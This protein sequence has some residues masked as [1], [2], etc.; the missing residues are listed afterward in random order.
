MH[1]NLQVIVYS[2]D[3]PW[4]LAEYLRTFRKFISSDI[5]PK[6]IW[7]ASNETF[8]KAYED[9]FTKGWCEPVSE[10]DH[11][12]TFKEL[13][14]RTIDTKIPY[15]LWG[16]DDILWYRKLDNFAHVPN[17][18]NKAFSYSLRLAP[19]VTFCQPANN[20]N[21]VPELVDYGGTLAYDR[22]NGWGD[23]DY[24]WDIGASIY[25]TINAIS[26][27]QAIEFNNPNEL[28]ANGAMLFMG[29]GNPNAHV[30][31]CVPKSLC[32]VVTINRAQNQFKNELAGPEHTLEELLQ[33]YW[34]GAEY[35]EE[36]YAS[37]TF[38][39]I[40]IGDFKLKEPMAA[41]GLR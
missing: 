40:H 6:V 15:I 21:K 26:V 41:Q 19:N 28:E 35:D 25:K 34:D 12:G 7:K 13:V 18:L 3:R 5:K 38:D 39:R 10:T 32:S 9:L 11:K 29:I 1:N 4:Q 16:V 20:I 36:W 8:T 2:K 31:C 17:F 23:F 33:L 24:P 22:R 30:N 37:Q 27:V 14:L